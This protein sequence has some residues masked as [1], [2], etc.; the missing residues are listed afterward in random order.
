[1]RRFIVGES[2][3]PTGLERWLLKGQNP[4]V[5]ATR[6][7][8]LRM[9]GIVALSLIL[10]LLGIGL[11]LFSFQR[12]YRQNDAQLIEACEVRNRQSHQSQRILRSISK[13]EQAENVSTAAAY[14]RLAD[15]A[16]DPER[17]RILRQLAKL[18]L[19]RDTAV[20]GIFRELADNIRF[21]DCATEANTSR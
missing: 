3:Q 16:T 21:P 17:A 20:A 7:A 13:A 9:R 10:A 2:G 8:M 5:P 12:D 11:M 6:L 19:G 4:E 15:R 1:M 18:E 14:N